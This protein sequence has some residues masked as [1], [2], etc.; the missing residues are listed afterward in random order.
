ME[1]KLTGKPISKRDFTWNTTLLWSRNRSYVRELADGITNQIIYG[2]NTNVTIE[3]RVGG[4]MGDMYGR[5]FQRSPEGQI[6]YQTNGLP[7][8]LDPV[9]R[10]WGNAFAD[11]KG[12]IQNEFTI[13][14]VRLSILL[15]GQKGGEMYSQTSHKNNTLGKTTVTL[16]GREEGVLGDGV[17]RRA[18]GTF[19]QNTTRAAASAYYDNFYQISNAETNI[20]DA[21]FLKI[22]EVRMEFNLP[23]RL[24]S[25]IGVQKTSVAVFGRE[26][27]N[28][29]KFPGFDPEGGNLNS[30]TL[31]PGVEL[32]QFPSAR[33]IGANL[34]FKF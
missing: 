32:T 12:S 9:A 30:G 1:V 6:I 3:A 4:R 2:H 24:L 19:V 22:R 34:T 10:L 11:W 33:N 14:N 17:V 13:K 29:T 16:P 21:S 26:L 31:T 28:F 5:G 27:F 23:A 7:A 8:P 25:R 20:F 15:D 18:D